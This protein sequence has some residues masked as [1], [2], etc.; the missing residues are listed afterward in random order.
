MSI[1]W[2]INRHQWLNAVSGRISLRFISNIYERRL[3]FG[4]RE[5]R[6]S[7]KA[8]AQRRSSHN[9]LP[10]YNDV[11][12]D[13]IASQITSLTVVYSTVYSDADQRNIKAPRHWPVWGEFT[14]DRW[15]P[16]T[17]GQWRGKCF[18]LMTSSCESWMMRNNKVFMIHQGLH[19]A[20][21]PQRTGPE[22]ST[23][24]RA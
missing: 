8:M 24:Q 3:L 22:S 14:G 21:E 11:T 2:D 1:P 7:L 20:R 6:A 16:R 13:V 4:A 10:H 15:I 17:N 18:H 23:T 9:A 12:M 5:V 19:F